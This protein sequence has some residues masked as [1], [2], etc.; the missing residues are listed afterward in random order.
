LIGGKGHVSASS[1]VRGVKWIYFDDEEL[2]G[3]EIIRYR[4]RRAGRT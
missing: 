2:A 1:L 4:I 3:V